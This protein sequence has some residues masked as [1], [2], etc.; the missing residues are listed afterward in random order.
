M[1]NLRRFAIFLYRIMILENE[2]D[3]ISNGFS[4]KAKQRIKNFDKIRNLVDLSLSSRI[5]R[6]HGYVADLLEAK[7]MSGGDLILLA[8]D[9]ALDQ[10]NLDISHCSAL[11]N[12]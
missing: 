6:L 1:A 7:S 3:Y 8:A 10:S 12:Q 9:G 5:N 11:L 4:E 2:K